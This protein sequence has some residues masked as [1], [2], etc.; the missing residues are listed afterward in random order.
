[1]AK[2][3]A[4]KLPVNATGFLDRERKNLEVSSFLN[5][6]FPWLIFYCMRFDVL[7]TLKM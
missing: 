4:T 1:M 6:L 3:K 5:K 2:L 7:M